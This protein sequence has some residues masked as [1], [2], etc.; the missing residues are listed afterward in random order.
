MTTREAA[1]VLDTV[2]TLSM[3]ELRVEVV[4]LDV[5]TVFGRTDYLVTPVAG[6]GTT[7]VDSDRTIATE[8]A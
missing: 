3:G 6:S 2:R 5:R 4:V 7:W 1:L 8:E